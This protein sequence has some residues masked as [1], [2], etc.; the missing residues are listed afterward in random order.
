[1]A[2]IHPARARESSTTGEAGLS[3]EIRA[4]SQIDARLKEASKIGFKKAI[5]PMT[6]AARLKETYG[7]EIT[8]VKN[9]DE[10]LEAVLG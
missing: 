6:N 9:V 2:R 7:M 1:V 4:V 8:G 3:G 10:F 5:L